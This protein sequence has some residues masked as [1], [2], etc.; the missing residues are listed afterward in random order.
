V[1]SKEN[2]AMNAR[3]AQQ[4]TTAF[5]MLGLVVFL[6]CYHTPIETSGDSPAPLQMAPGQE[7]SAHGNYEDSL[8]GGQ[9]FTM[10]CGY[11]HFPR[12]LAERPLASYKNAAAHMR[13]VA[14]LTGKEQAKLLE[15]L[16]RWHDVPAAEQRETPALNRFFYSQPINELRQ[17]QPKPAPDLPGGP[18]PG[19]S[20]EAGPGQPPPGSSPQEAR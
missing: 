15:Y 8:S 5:L 10:Y 1:K 17:Q 7:A 18:R 6:G 2:E 19:A 13:V 3:K 12:S 11:C 20:N 4:T 14:D 16:R 9:I